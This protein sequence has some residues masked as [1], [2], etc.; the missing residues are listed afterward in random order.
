MN[1]KEALA[2]SIKTAIRE[3]EWLIEAQVGRGHT[4]IE[5]YLYPLPVREAIA[6]HF[7]KLGFLSKNLMS[8][9]SISWYEPLPEVGS[10]QRHGKSS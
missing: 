1:A 9:V 7:K 10:R 5:T 2:E 4:S 3:T 8:T 6:I